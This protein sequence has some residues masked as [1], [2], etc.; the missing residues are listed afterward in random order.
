MNHKNATLAIAAIVAAV[1]MTAV[2]FAIPQQALA[3]GHHH[4]N[5]NNSV[6]VTQNISQANLCSGNTTCANDAHN[7]ADIDR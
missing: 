7:N 4:Y 1:A 2:A 6:D 5:H 3:G